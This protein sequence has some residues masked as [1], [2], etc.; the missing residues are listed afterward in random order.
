MKRLFQIMAV[1]A[2]GL[3]LTACDEEIFDE[4][5]AQQILDEAGK[6]R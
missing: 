2:A 1:L 4:L 5:S 3:A 6:I